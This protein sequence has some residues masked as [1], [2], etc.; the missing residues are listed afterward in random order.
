MRIIQRIVAASLAL[1]LLM[2]HTAQADMHF[3]VFSAGWNWENTPVEVLLKADVETHMPFDADRLSML[4]P[5]TDMLSLRLVT[6]EDQGAVTIAIEEQEVLSL[7]YQGNQVQLS[8]MPATTYTSDTDTISMLLGTDVSFAGGYEALGLDRRSETLL[9]DGR[10]LLSQIPAA[11]EAYGKRA[12]TDMNIS[13]Y[14]KSAYRYDYTIA[15]AK[16][17]NVREMLLSICPDGWLKEII[18]ALNFSGQQTLRM[19]YTA[20]DVLLRAE[21]NGTCG[22]SDDL[23][24]VKLVIRTR[25]D[26][27]V[28]KDYLELTSPAKKGK[29]KNN[30]TFERT[31]QMN[32]PGKR[33]ITGNYTYTVISEGITSIQKAEFDLK[34]DYTDAADHITGSIS[35]ESKLNGAEKYTGLTLKPDLKIT[36]EEEAPVVNGTLAVTETYAGKTTEHAVLTIVLQRAEGIAWEDRAETVDLSAL[37]AEALADAQQQAAASITAAM[38]HPL[39]LMM[40]EEAT[41]FFQDLPADAVQKIIETAEM[42]VN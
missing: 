19:Y 37:D 31:V 18:G 15:A 6:G 33:T 13:G 29:D 35:S 30:L 17:G 12:K 20:D 21:Y 14:G 7:Q 36:G 16:A 27:E 1:L 22:A 3:Q 5:I 10:T 42:P 8:S 32:Q 40:G 23:R 24:T 25:Q 34:N 2:I 28:Q 39:I 4:T 26:E 41:W 38:V 9:S 11:F